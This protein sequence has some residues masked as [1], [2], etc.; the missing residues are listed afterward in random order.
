MERKC[1]E[2]EFSDRCILASI[3]H[4]HQARILWQIIIVELFRVLHKKCFLL[5]HLLHSLKPPKK[6]QRK[7]NRLYRMPSEFLH[8]FALL[9]KYHRSYRIRS[10]S[11]MVFIN[12]SRLS[13]HDL[14][15]TKGYSSDIAF[16]RALLL[17]LCVM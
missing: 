4:L 3:L 12:F 10:F 17:K 14:F 9:Q 15:C 6:R 7:K 2:S 16:C 1:N 5:C 11:H 8:L 13:F